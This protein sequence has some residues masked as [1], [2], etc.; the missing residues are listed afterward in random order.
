MARFPTKNADPRRTPLDCTGL[1]CEVG[2]RVE[3]ECGRTGVVVKV[4]PQVDPEYR[5]GAIVHNG[6]VVRYDG[7]RWAGRSVRLDTVMSAASEWRVLNRPE[8]T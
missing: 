1:V 4:R 8:G 5:R 7:P 3:D 6:I 2:D